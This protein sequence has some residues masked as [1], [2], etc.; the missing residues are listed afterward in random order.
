[1]I[2]L[3]DQQRDAIA[4]LCREH[5]IRRLAVFGSA[6]KGTWRLGE[7]DIDVLIHLDDGPGVGRRYMRFSAALEQLLDAPVDIVTERSVDSHWFREELE[8]T[9]VPIYDAGDAQAIA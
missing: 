8:N 3:I 7:S 9:A 4:Q 6:A 1:M 5:G 2:A